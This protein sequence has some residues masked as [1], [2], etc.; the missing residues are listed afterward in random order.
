VIDSA[1]ARE[2]ASWFGSPGTNGVV[3]AE[4]AGTGTVRRVALDGAITREVSLIKARPVL[5]G[6][7]RDLL[8][9]L[10]ALRRWVRRPN[11]RH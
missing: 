11:E 8:R 10:Y 2:I 1:A 9:C 3:F 4:L 6:A 5:E 7:D